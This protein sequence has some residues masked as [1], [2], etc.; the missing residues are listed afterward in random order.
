MYDS[1]V[2]D[3]FERIEMKKI[4][5]ACIISICLLVL[6]GCIW[7]KYVN[8]IESTEV[9]NEAN[10]QVDDELDSRVVEETKVFIIDNFRT[11][12]VGVQV[13]YN[14]E[15]NIMVE[16]VKYHYFD[17]VYN[18]LMGEKSSVADNAITH[19]FVDIKNRVIYEAVEGD[20]DNY[21]IGRLLID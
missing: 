18:L 7:C 21:S 16:G 12:T 5:V 4:R 20:N 9:E 1:R 17:L 10:T 11:P 2:Y 19:V 14:S 13:V 3:M 15:H 8:I 6:L